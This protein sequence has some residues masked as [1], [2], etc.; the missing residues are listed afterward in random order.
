[1]TRALANFRG[2]GEAPRAGIVENGKIFTVPVDVAGSSF[3]TLADLYDR[4]ITVEPL[5]A[6]LTLSGGTPVD[7][8]ELLAPS[9]TPSAIFCMGANYQ[10]HVDA[11]YRHQKMPSEA[12]LVELGVPPWHFLKARNT[13]RGHKSTIPLFTDHVDWEIELAAIIGRTARNV[14][15]DRALDY[16]AGYTIGIDLSA[17]DKGIRSAMNVGSPFRYDWVAH[18]SFEGACPL[19][20]W[21]V[22]ARLLGDPQAVDLRLA[23][24][25]RVRQN[26]NTSKML[27]STAEQIAYLSTVISLSPGDVVLTGTPAGTGFESDEY[28]QPGDVIIASIPGIGELSVTMSANSEGNR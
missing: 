6:E 27:Y 12:S 23:V 9:L 7:D 26:S 25:G 13:L 5:L 22:P 21:L 1:M 3:A 14:S 28:L 15:I 10:E 16:V 11:V 8:V 2:P 20:P 24:N 19:G 4:W 17:R 18:K